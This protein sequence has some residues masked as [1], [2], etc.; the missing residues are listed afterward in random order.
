[1]YNSLIFE[2][3]EYKSMSITIYNGVKITL[4]DMQTQTLNNWIKNLIIQV[5]TMQE[6]IFAQSINE[7]L[8]NVTNKADG[9]SILQDLDNKI[10][11]YRNSSINHHIISSDFYI[12]IIPLQDYYIGAIYCT[13]KNILD[14]IYK[15]TDIKEYYYFDNSDKPEEI[16]ELSWSKRESDWYVGLNGYDLTINEAGFNYESYLNVNEIITSIKLQ[17]INNKDQHIAIEYIRENFKNK[18]S[19]YMKFSNL[20]INV[21]ARN[22]LDT[23]NQECSKIEEYIC[24]RIKDNNAQSMNNVDLVDLYSSEKLSIILDQ[25]L[26]LGILINKDSKFKDI[27]E[28]TMIKTTEESYIQK[29]LNVFRLIN[30][31]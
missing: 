5:K 21:D 13:S 17:N 25:N 23:F 15:N 20:K 24:K 11:H 14:N 7:V 2:I 30:K 8:K 1:M 29:S 6:S 26:E 27:L 19:I 16:S 18:K 28:Y 10:N 9:L 12:S 4:K 22:F 31:A 3:N